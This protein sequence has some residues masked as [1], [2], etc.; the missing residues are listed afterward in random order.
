MCHWGCWR[1]EQRKLVINEPQA[2]WQLSDT[3]G[4]WEMANRVVMHSLDSKNPGVSCRMSGLTNV[5]SYFPVSVNR[6]RVSPLTL[7]GICLKQVL[8]WPN[9]FFSDLLTPVSSKFGGKHHKSIIGWCI[10]VCRLIVSKG[11]VSIQ[12]VQRDYVVRSDVLCT[13]DSSRDKIQLLELIQTGSLDSSC[14]ASIA[15]CRT[16]GGSF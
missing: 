13:E 5:R 10:L 15:F 1:A 14:N 9:C 4:S 11:P 6:A 8:A 12:A 3:R 7:G 2:N 16:R